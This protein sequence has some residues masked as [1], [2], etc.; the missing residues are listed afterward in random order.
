M[1]VNVLA[2]TKEARNEIRASTER[3][4]R[5]TGFSSWVIFNSHSIVSLKQLKFAETGMDQQLHPLN[6]A[7]NPS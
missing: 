7:E 3:F 6:A 2:I 4:T 1:V 5:L